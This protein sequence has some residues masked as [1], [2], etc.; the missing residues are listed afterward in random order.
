MC[1]CKALQYLAEDEQHEEN[2]G[3]TAAATARHKAARHEADTQLQ[4]AS[5]ILPSPRQ[6][7]PGQEDKVS[8]TSNI[9]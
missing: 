6:A 9:I 3:R 5:Q 2:T 4:F 1:V 8:P 7:W